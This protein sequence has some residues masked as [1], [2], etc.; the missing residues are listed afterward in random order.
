MAE[1]Q[2][3]SF[4]PFFLTEPVYLLPEEEKTLEEAVAVEAAAENQPAAETGDR[5]EPEQDQ[6]EKPVYEGKN[7]RQVMILVYNYADARLP[8][9]DKALLG[10]IL[11]ALDLDFEDVA[12]CNWA[13][14]QQKADERPDIYERLNRIDADKVI[15]FGDL[16]GSWS[17]THFFSKY[18]I[19]HDQAGTA[20]LHSDGLLEIAQNKDLKVLLWDSLQKLFGLKS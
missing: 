13:L 5:D 12:L 1:D 15:A 9:A 17:C 2:D 20:F 11:Q 14:L 18:H 7:R 19:S 10:K 8:A 6:L 3:L 16:P 4:L